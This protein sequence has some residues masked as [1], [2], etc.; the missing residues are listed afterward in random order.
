MGGIPVLSY[1]SAE[2][3]PIDLDVCLNGQPSQSLAHVMS[4]ASAAARST[5]GFPAEKW[6]TSEPPGVQSAS[7][8]TLFGA[9]PTHR[10]A[11]PAR[12]RICVGQ[13]EPHHE[14]TELAGYCF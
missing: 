10:A 8:P 11:R 13:P 2:G 4:S 14:R 3:W 9:M 12:T 1:S 6:S 5:T 7:S